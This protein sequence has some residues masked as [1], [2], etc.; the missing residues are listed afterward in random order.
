[1]RWLLIDRV[2]H[3]AFYLLTKI[4]GINKSSV[5]T[6]DIKH[7]ST[8]KVA[9]ATVDTP[10]VD[11]EGWTVDGWREDE[12][13]AVH[14]IEPLGT[15]SMPIDT[16][17]YA[18]YKR[19]AV[20]SSGVN[21]ASTAT[22]TQYYNTTNKFSLLTPSGAS[23]QPIAG[24]TAKNW[25]SDGGNEVAFGERYTD[26][27]NVF[28]AKYQRTI[29][30][31]HGVN[32][33]SNTGATQTYTSD[34][35][36]K[37][38]T[39]A[40]SKAT[41]LGNSWVAQD[42]LQKDDNEH[43]AGAVTYDG[44]RNIFY[45]YY[46]RNITINYTANG[47]TGTTNATT[48]EQTYDSSDAI[49][50]ASLNLANNAFKRTGYRFTKWD[51]GN[52][53]AAVNF[54]VAD[55]ATRTAAAQWAGFVY[56]VKYAAGTATGGWNAST[57]A[58][59][60]ATYPTNI[61]LRTNNMT[62]NNTE[63][64]GSRFRVTFNGNGGSVSPGTADT[65]IPI[66]YTKNGWTTTSGSTTR[67]YTNGQ[68]YNRT[69]ADNTT[70]TLYPCFSQTQQ[71][72]TAITAPTPSRTNMTCTG[73]WTATSGG[74]KV[75]S[76]GV[77]YTNV[78]KSQTV[79]AQWTNA[80]ANIGAG[81]NIFAEG[82]GA[83]S[84]GSENYFYYEKWIFKVKF[85]LLAGKTWKDMINSDEYKWPVYFWCK[86]GRNKYPD[87]WTHE[88]TYTTRASLKSAA[89]AQTNSYGINLKNCVL[90]AAPLV[91]S[92]YT[93]GQVG[94]SKTSFKWYPSYADKPTTANCVYFKP[95]GL[96]YAN[97]KYSDGCNLGFITTGQTVVRVTR[98]YSSGSWNVCL[99]KNVI[100]ETNTINLSDVGKLLMYTYSDTNNRSLSPGTYSSGNN[101]TNPTNHVFRYL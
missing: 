39:P 23:A 70:I 21:K 84:G 24:F 26:S 68:A 31:Y 22:A 37:V 20:F 66:A 45:A 89:A 34:D 85:Q 97:S 75:F 69:D 86:R 54:G 82:D 55:A 91:G 96:G 88:C 51:I 100:P 19:D 67:N 64:S 83:T 94:T 42:W 13:A 1:M 30:F 52:A 48:A 8:I 99:P 36:Y 92:D 80:T 74:S 78:G 28:Y 18:V 62:K 59:Q 49:S 101:Y 90:K 63:K 38:D 33:A 40:I 81:S 6:Q 56:T 41:D 53:G 57:Y 4:S 14:T 9:E 93:N 25:I 60:S 17:I 7:F 72:R 16:T 47:G 58:N 32:K 76:C 87:D 29:D 2:G 10:P 77:K 5:V 35:I 43:V 44:P 15:F 46:K 95:S 73:W 27:S 65:Y 71:A 50:P 79:Y 98:T 3:L 11:I 12:V 61:T